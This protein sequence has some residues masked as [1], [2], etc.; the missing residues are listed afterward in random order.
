MGLMNCFRKHSPGDSQS[1]GE[2]SAV[3]IPVNILSGLTKRFER[4]KTNVG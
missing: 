4:S 1:P 2:D 3:S